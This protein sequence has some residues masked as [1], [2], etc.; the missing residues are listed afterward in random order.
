MSRKKNTPYNEQ[1]KEVVDYL[2]VHG[3]AFFI[4][5]QNKPCGGWGALWGPPFLDI[6]VDI[7]GMRDLTFHTYFDKG[8]NIFRI[9][10]GLPGCFNLFV[11]ISIG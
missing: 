7:P 4:H 9:S 10:C 11:I 8:I 6:P 3:A 2:M 1:I 5:H